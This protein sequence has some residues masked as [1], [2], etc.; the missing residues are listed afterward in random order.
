MLAH[1][2]TSRAE[3]VHYK[4]VLK[5]ASEVPSV[6]ASGSGVVNATYN[7]TTRRLTWEGSYSGL[8]GPAN[9]AHIHGPAGRSG[10]AGP[11]FW[12]SDNVGQCDK[13][14][15]RFKPRMK[16]PLHS[17]FEGSAELTDDEAGQL[18]DG[19]LYVNIHTDAHPAG[20]LRGQ[21]LRAQ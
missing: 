1:V 12:I 17:P 3:L 8:S 5:P 10:N 19:R 6:K 21:L 2:G 18:A 11:L 4:A 9:A 13:G 14:G 15:C 20:E 16:A 7:T